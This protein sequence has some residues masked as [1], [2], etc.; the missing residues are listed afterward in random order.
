MNSKAMKR[1]MRSIKTIFMGFILLTIYFQ[2]SGQKIEAYL[3]AD[4]K[5]KVST[6]NFSHLLFLEY[7]LAKV[8]RDTSI[9]NRFTKKIELTNK[10]LARYSASDKKEFVLL[11]NALLEKVNAITTD[12]N[13]V[14]EGRKNL[15][16][17]LGP[18]KNA[19]LKLDEKL[20][21]EQL[22]DSKRGMT[23]G[24]DEGA[25]DE[26]QFLFFTLDAILLADVVK[27]N[28][29]NDS[30]ERLGTFLC[31]NII[32][33]GTAKVIRPRIYQAVKNNLA[34]LKTYPHF[35]KIKSD[36]DGCDITS[37]LFD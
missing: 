2:S 24:Y 36:L 13:D 14:N 34:R 4:L 21:V 35:E 9:S 11:L 25:T 26:S 10:S 5:K 8:C 6:V 7:E 28:G 1:A 17:I 30:W 27:K 20:V 3:M 33:N 37:N 16:A 29:M 12:D 15:Q 19:Q 32:D 18:Y 22:N 31:N 23:N